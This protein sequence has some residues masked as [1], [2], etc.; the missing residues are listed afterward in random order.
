MFEDMLNNL[1]NL[2][3]RMN[4]LK[5]RLDS[6]TVVGE[7]PGGEVS[8]SVNGNKQVKHVD[9]RYDLIKLGDK[10]QI[11]DLLTIAINR[12]MEKA[13]DVADAEGAALSKEMLPSMPGFPGLT[14]S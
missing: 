1:S 7:A 9:I 3:T 4:D 6:I 14:G 2:Q 5:I 10:D 8:V 12:A 13:Q 11:E